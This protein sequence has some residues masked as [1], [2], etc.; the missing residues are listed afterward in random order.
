MRRVSVNIELDSDSADILVRSIESMVE[1]MED[2]GV[3]IARIEGHLLE[4]SEMLREE[5]VGEAE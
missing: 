4:I 2:L 1:V 5:R 3:S